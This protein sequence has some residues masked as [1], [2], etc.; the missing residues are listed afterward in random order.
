M[1]DPTDATDPTDTL[2][3]LGATAQ[4]HGWAPITV[5]TD[6][7]AVTAYHPHTAWRL[8]ALWSSDHFTIEALH[9]GRNIRHTLLHGTAAEAEYALRDPEML[10]LALRAARDLLADLGTIDLRTD[11]AA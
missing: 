1:S 10:D 9:L 8:S 3:R 4:H 11:T 5:D 6:N 7:L 2:A